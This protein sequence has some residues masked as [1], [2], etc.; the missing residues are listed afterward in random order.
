MITYN[1]L[2]VKINN[3]EKNVYFSDGLYICHRN[4]AMHNHNHTELHVIGFDGAKYIIDGKEYEFSAGDVVGMPAGMYHMPL[5]GGENVKRNAFQV[6]MPLSSL[7]I[8]H[9]SPDIVGAFFVEI[10]K[11]NASGDYLRLSLYISL[12]CCEFF[13]ADILPVHPVTDYNMLIHEFFSRNYN[14]DIR[15]CDLASVLHL[16]EKQAERLVKKHTGRTFKGALSEKRIEMARYLN[17]TTELSLCEIA[18][19]VGYRSYSGFWKAI[20]KK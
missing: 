10:Q 6:D 18:E 16:S 8:K 20:N 5:Y 12:I 3:K 1:E 13:D 17:E 15:L 14:E 2:N 19:K 7:T 11:S 4:T 9:F